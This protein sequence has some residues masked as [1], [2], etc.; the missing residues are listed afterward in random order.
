MLEDTIPQQSGPSS[1]WKKILT[2]VTLLAMAA[3][4]FTLR[5]QIADVIDNFRKVNLYFLW[6]MIPLQILNYD[7]YA[8][9]YREFFK[10]LGSKVKY[11]DM[12]KLS[13]ELNMVN[14]LLP[15]GGVSGISYF[16]LRMKS[17]GVSTAR[18][19]LAQVMKFALVFVSFQI[20]LA[21]GLLALAIRGHAS[22]LM[23][24]IAGSLSTLLF[25]GTGISIYVI[26]DKKR[27]KS[28]LLA[29]TRLLNRILHVFRRKNPETFNVSRAQ[30]V[31]EELHD[32]YVLM[33][34]RWTE[35]RRPLFFSLVA[36]ITEVL[37]VYVVF[38]A[39]GEKV[40]IGAVI[41]AYAIANFAGLLSVLPGGIGVYEAL[42]TATLAATGVEASLSIP[43]IIMYRVLNIGLQLPPGY[44]YY[45]KAI[46]SGGFEVQK[47]A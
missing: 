1:R 9:L 29:V 32:N 47:N 10:I 13:L 36:N 31:F 23:I 18:S 38:L 28:F 4:A 5:G 15:S 41:I 6:L 21:F 39:F 24:L 37:T 27:I 12:F 8:R 46:Q 45:H 42:M 44:Y 11:S 30:D 2:V 33:K 14:H 26:E 40:N 25:V 3:L 43:V 22:N 34:H 35:L 19:T 16:S 20:L 7:A 17:F